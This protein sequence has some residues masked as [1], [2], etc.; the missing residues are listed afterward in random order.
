MKGIK[1]CMNVYG[2]DYVEISNNYAL[3][4]C[5]SLEMNWFIQT[6]A[7]QGKAGNIIKNH[8][9]TWMCHVNSLTVQM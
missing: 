8:G 3:S 1:M 2:C 4:F 9:G 6:P 7:R 5:F